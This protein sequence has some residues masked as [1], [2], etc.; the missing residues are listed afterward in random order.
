LA[1]SITT[2]VN[3]ANILQ[4]FSYKKDEEKS[5]TKREVVNQEATV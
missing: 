1:K 3:I 4:L 5:D 2:N